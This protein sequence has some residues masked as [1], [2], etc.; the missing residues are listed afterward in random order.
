MACV[1]TARARLAGAMHWSLEC[2]SKASF[3]WRLLQRVLIHLCAPADGPAEGSQ[4]AGV[5]PSEGQGGTGAGGEEPAAE[6]CLSGPD[7]AGV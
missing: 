1:R 4:S 7:I 2:W 6:R 5:L 3:H